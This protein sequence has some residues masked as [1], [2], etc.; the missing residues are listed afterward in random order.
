[1]TTDFAKLVKSFDI[2]ALTTHNYSHHIL[3]QTS[4]KL[5][6]SFVDTSALKLFT[7]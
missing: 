6:T 1:M 3:Y 4:V 2:S 5:E 7:D